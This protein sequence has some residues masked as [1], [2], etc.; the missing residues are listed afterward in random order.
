VKEI[1]KFYKWLWNEL[2]QKFE[3]TF[4]HTGCGLQSQ[5]VAFASNYYQ[6]CTTSAKEMKREEKYIKLHAIATRFCYSIFIEPKNRCYSAY[7]AE[8]KRLLSHL[9]ERAFVGFSVSIQSEHTYCCLVIVTIS[10]L[11]NFCDS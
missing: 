11:C 9:L 5:T 6:I 3:L 4:F 10:F 2:V 1:K 8:Q 7:T